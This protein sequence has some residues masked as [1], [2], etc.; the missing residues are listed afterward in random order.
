MPVDNIWVFGESQDQRPVVVTLELLTKARELGSTVSVF[1]VGAEAEGLSDEFGKY[2]ARKV[3]MVDPGDALPGAAAAKAMADLIEQESPDLIMF[4]TTYTGRDVCGTLSVILDHPVISNGQG[5][6]VEGD[7]VVVGTQI[8]GGQT[9]VETAFRCPAP[10]LAL[11]RPKSFT[12]EPADG[13]G[14]PE[15][16]KVELPDVGVQG[17]ARVLERHVEKAEG[18]KLEEAAIVVSGGRGLGS[19]E[20]YKLVDDL[21]ELLKAAKGASRAIV[22][23]GWVPYSHQVG[24]TGKVVK[25]KVYIALGISGAMQHMVGM[26][27]SGHIIA[28]NKDAEAP[29]FSVASLGVVGDV[30]KVVPALI[31]A[32]KSR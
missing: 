15:V 27:D 12:A 29:I 32:L 20:N 7:E 6:N 5:L 8:F 17:Q 23:A 31:D 26:K 28:I 9:I 24:Q 16:V 2:G 11:I 18:P 14:S 21:A 19:A 30:H 25:P 10:H 3:Y 1:Y 4:P 22:D 13:G